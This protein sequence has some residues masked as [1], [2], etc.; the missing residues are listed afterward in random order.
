MAGKMTGENP[1]ISA[2]GTRALPSLAPASAPS[3]LVSLDAYRGF[4]MLLMAS[5]GLNI[6][7]VARDFKDSASWQFLAYQTSHAPWRGCAMWDLIQPSFMFMVGVA[8]PYSLAS[9]QAKGARF[10]ELLRH[11]LVRSLVL[12]LLGVFLRS[13]GKSQTYF[14]FEDVLSQ[15]GFGYPF[16]FLLAWTRPRTQA[17][18]AVAILV[19]TW[20]AFAL[21]PLPPAGFDTATVGVPA[22]W[23]YRLEG[24]A[25]HWDKNT[26]LAHAF[27]VWFLNLLPHKSRFVF[28]AGGYLTLNFVP[29]LAT[30]IFGMLAGG[31]LRGTRETRKTFRVLMLVGVAG[32]GLGWLLDIAGI[33][34]SVKRIWTPSWAIF[35]TGWTC[36]LL[37]SFYALIDLHRWRRAAFPLVVV[38]MN[39][40]AMYGLAHLIPQ[41]IL[42]TFRTHIGN[43]V[44]ALAGPFAP[45]AE[46]ATVLVVLWL[47]VFWMYR[48]KI[49]LRI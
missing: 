49:F 31:L 14:T 8:M 15:I 5:E 33:C 21:Y 22:D 24:F 19:V 20:A 42:G 2:A 46:A 3:R 10:G 18:A 30:M 29:S 16:L 1:T 32:V 9:R 34:P 23:P 36:L 4:V 37:G 40:I 6:P 47:M 25:R 7:R 26:N 35:S 17:L 44:F 13:V 11:A 39:S 45:V 43:N 27:D 28:N 12:V 48:R 38:G 41:F